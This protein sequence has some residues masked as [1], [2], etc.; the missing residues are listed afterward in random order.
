MNF[1]QRLIHEPRRSA[2]RGW[3]FQIHLYSGLIAALYALLIGITG[4]ALVF[5]PQ[6]RN[7]QDRD[8]LRVQ[9]TGIR[10]GADQIL[11]AVR[12]ARPGIHIMSLRLP[13]EERGTFR[14]STGHMGKGDEIYVNPFTGRIVGDQG[15]RNDFLTWLQQLHFNLL[16]GPRGRIVN[17]VGGLMMLLLAATGLVIWWPGKALWR[18]AMTVESRAGWKRINYDLHSA[19]GFFTLLFT[20]VISL[21]GAY[22]AWPKQTQRFI[23]RVSPIVQKAAAPRL[24]KRESLTEVPVSHLLDIAA[25]AAPGAWVQSVNFAHQHGQPTRIVLMTG[26]GRQYQYTNTVYLDPFTGKLLRA[27]LVTGRS[28]GDAIIAWI[29]PLHFGTF[30]GGVPVYVLWLVLG[31]SPAFLGASGLLM[32]WNRVAVKRV[33][34]WRLARGETSKRPIRVANELVH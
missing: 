21:T 13:V 28:F 23:S 2:V 14:V 30:G 3:I 17:G 6:M 11:D 31:L 8:L 18:R 9:E 12:Q 24:P 1:A 7:L 32:W 19:T 29:P 20:I 5:Y 4:S 26:D 10:L 34:K 33:W 16:A 15:P 27:D 22:Y 25:A